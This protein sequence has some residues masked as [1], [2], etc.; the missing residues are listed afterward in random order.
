MASFNMKLVSETYMGPDG[1]TNFLG[2]LAVLEAYEY[3]RRAMKDGKWVYDARRD[4]DDNNMFRAATLAEQLLARGDYQN[5]LR[6]A[7]VE[8]R[9]G[10]AI[11]DQSGQHAYQIAEMAL[12][13]NDWEGFRAA[14]EAARGMGAWAYDPARTIREMGIERARTTGNTEMLAKLEDEAARE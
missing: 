9:F 6:A 3:P 1:K 14:L 8:V 5:A 7:Q 12:A 4:S 11:L 2:E 10:C 13:N